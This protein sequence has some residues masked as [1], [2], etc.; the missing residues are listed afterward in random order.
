[1]PRDVRSDDERLA[2]T[3]ASV[4]Q[5]PLEYVM[6]NFPWDTEESIQVVP[7]PEKYRE[8]FPGVEYGPDK[9]ACEFLDE[10]GEQIRA[11]NFDGHKPVAPIRFST[12]SGHEIGK[13]ALVAWLIKFVLDTRPMSKGSVTAVTDEQLRTKTWAEL[14]KWHAMSLTR[15]WFKYTSARGSMTLSHTDDRYAGTWRCD[16]RTCREEKSEAFA[17]QHAPTATSFYIFDEASGVPDKV[18]EVREGGLTSGEP[19]V[20]D[21]GNGT[22]NSGAFFENCEG[23]RAKRYSTR[24]IDSR[25]VRITNKDK[26]AEDIEDYGEDSDFVRVRWLGLFPK[27][28]SMQFISSAEVRAAMG[29]EVPSGVEMHRVVLGVDVARFGDDRSVIYPRRGMDARSF[30]PRLYSGLDTVQLADA[31]A[32]EF[33]Y[34]EGLGQRPAAIFVDEGGVG[35]GVVDQLSHRG[36]PVVGIN[37]GGKPT[38]AKTYRYKADEMWGL[39]RKAMPKLALPVAGEASQVLYDDLTQREYGFTVA[40]AK[41][42]MESKSDMKKRGL[43]S[44][45]IGDALALTFAQEVAVL[46]LPMGISG[47]AEKLADWDYDPHAGL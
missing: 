11:R 39:M 33:A 36:F 27:T 31:V 25:S 46:E 45:D 42:N 20:F 9:W 16:A 12:V 7:L 41:I 18:F 38:D 1:M 8:R 47:P 34:F 28:G 30:E 43:R 14:G 23:K 4:R 13:S 10:L 29:R 24:S 40:G 44:P 21:F 35:G 6:F 3:L 37:F 32:R 19:M 26:I 17:G 5:Y 22:K 15:H 2:D